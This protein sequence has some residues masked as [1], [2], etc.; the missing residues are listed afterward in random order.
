MRQATRRSIATSAGRWFG[1]ALGAVLIAGCSASSAAPSAAPSA[2]AEAPASAAASTPA[3]QASVTPPTSSAP[4]SMETHEPTA[5]PTAIDPCA[6][7]TPSEVNALTGASFSTGEEG[8][9]GGHKRCTYGE[10]GIDF[11]VVVAEAPDAATAQSVKKSTE[12]EL[13]KNAA[14]LPITV[15]DLPDF[16]SGVDATVVEGSA[17]FGGGKYSATAIYIIRGAT[18]FSLTSISS[19]GAK[20][21]TSRAMQDQARVALG[22]LP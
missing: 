9:S 19:L 7:A 20:P 18:F 14:G 2:V 12:A 3:V 21:P 13:K 17:D 6:L 15:T 10:E 8:T 5:V 16:A 4:T 22:R 11:V 1:A